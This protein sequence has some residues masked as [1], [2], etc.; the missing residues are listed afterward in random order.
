MTVRWHVYRYDPVMITPHD[1]SPGLCWVC[2]FC[3]C[4]FGKMKNET[5]K[6]PITKIWSPKM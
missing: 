1:L 4:L 2:F 3:H 6:L 5:M